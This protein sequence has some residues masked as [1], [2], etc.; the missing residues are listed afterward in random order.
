MNRR[1]I[2]VSM[3]A[4]AM[5]ATSC[6]KDENNDKEINKPQVEVQKTCP[7]TIKAT[8]KS[9]ISKVALGT[10]NGD[11]SYKFQFQDNETMT[12]T[13]VGDNPI[14]YTLTINADGVGK[15]TATFSG[16]INEDDYGKTFTASITKNE[17]SGVGVSSAYSSL[18]AAVNNNNKFVSS[19]FTLTDETEITLQDQYVYIGLDIEYLYGKSLNINNASIQLNESGTT[20]VVFSSDNL[21]IPDLNLSTTVARGN[22]YTITRTNAQKPTAAKPTIDNYSFDIITEETKALKTTTDMEYSTDDGISWHD[23]TTSGEINGLDAYQTYQIQ[24]RVKGNDYLNASEAVTVDIPQMQTINTNGEMLTTIYYLEG[25]T[26]GTAANYTVN[27]SISISVEGDNIIMT[28]DGF[29]YK[30]KFMDYNTQST[31]DVSPNDKVTDDASGKYSWE[32]Y[33]YTPEEP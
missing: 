12:I 26:W 11:Q 32:E 9:G 1:F 25:N 6:S 5:F 17:L 18:E 24:I 21:S 28:N 22:Y 10:E 27:S 16:E 15:N 14:T 2:L 30:L 31:S 7:I 29:I 13:S 23:V 19:E 4:A 20:W 8:N 3:L 33:V